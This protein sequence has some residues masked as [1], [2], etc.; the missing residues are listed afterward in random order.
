MRFRHPNKLLLFNLHF[1][2]QLGNLCTLTLVLFHIHQTEK[3]MQALG[4]LCK[5]R[6]KPLV[7]RHQSEECVQ[8]I[9]ILYNW[10]VSYLTYQS[11]IGRDSLS[12]CNITQI[13]ILA[14]KIFCLFFW[15][16]LNVKILKAPK[17]QPDLIH[18][19]PNIWGKNTNIIHIQQ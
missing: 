17:D 4:N 8:F 9:S 6:Y 7:I 1:V 16:N 5:A 10:P 15:L 19:S 3:L 2:V 13:I 11:L 18:H 14:I 12:W